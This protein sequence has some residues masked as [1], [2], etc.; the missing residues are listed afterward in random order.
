ML[1]DG[2]ACGLVGNF[3]SLITG[4]R[5]RSARRGGRARRTGCRE[6]HA[7]IA[8]GDVHAGAQLGSVLVL[9]LGC[10]LKLALLDDSRLAEILEDVALEPFKLLRDIR[11]LAMHNVDLFARRQRNR[12]DHLAALS[13]NRGECNLL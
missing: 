8:A 13:S 3:P 10:E 9:V 4:E 7:A 12:V 6:R 2:P 5:L 11:P 1:L